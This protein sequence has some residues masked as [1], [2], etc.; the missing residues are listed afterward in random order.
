MSSTVPSKILVVDDI[1]ENLALIA[2]LLASADYDVRAVTSGAAALDAVAVDIPDL[3]LLDI[4]MPE[5]DGFEVCARLKADPRTVDVPVIF[6][7]ASGVLS[8]KLEAFRRGGADYVEKPFREEEML[9][10]VNVHVSLRKTR[11]ELM[12]VLASLENTVAERT[13]SLARREAQY[14]RLVEN[15]PDIIYSR[16]T[17]RGFLYA[18]NRLREILGYDIS[19]LNRN[20]DIWRNSVHPEDRE[21]YER[22]LAHPEHCEGAVLEY[23]IRDARDVWHWLEERITLVQPGDD[24]TLIDGLATEVTERVDHRQAM[25]TLAYSDLLT[26]LAN[27]KRLH[28]YINHLPGGKAAEYSLL[29][30]DLDRFKEINDA[31]G[32]QIGDRVLV[33][34]GERLRAAAGDGDILVARL[35]GEDFALVIACASQQDA[36]SCAQRILS[37]L[38][39]PFELDGMRLE[40]SGSIGIA[41][42]PRDGGSAS[43][44]L[45]CADVA[46]YIAKRTLAGYSSYSSKT[47]DNSPVHPAL[48]SEFSAAI[49]LGQL[50]LFYQP[51]MHLGSGAIAGFEALLRWH[52]PQHGLLLPGQF[53]PLVE[54]TDLIR[55]L[56][57]WVIDTALQQLKS[58]LSGGL[59]L[60]V[61][62]NLSA[63]NLLDETIPDR[64]AKCLTLHAI[65]P[66][67]LEVEITET[68]MLIDPDRS[69]GI[70]GRIAALGVGLAVDDFG[71][72]YSSF[73][74]VHRF[75]KPPGLKI[76]SSFVQRMAVN[77]TDA[78]IVASMIHLAHSIEARAIAEGVEDM[79]T[80]EVLRSLGCHQVQGY[81]LARPMPAAEVPD[82]LARHEESGGRRFVPQADQPP[83]PPAVESALP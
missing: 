58:W 15:A 26:G 83:P 56:T 4:R 7:S 46:M 12:S 3:V 61:A 39:H 10:R 73:S 23:R 28:E 14:K 22:I 66:A 37:A 36:E 49:D 65:D 25:E 79:Q 51:K 71:T 70:L 24:E 27:R 55:P 53:L 52:H 67:Q 77:P 81:L 42:A 31:L 44:M 43:E 16:S 54:V 45:R 75:P 38:D 17:R 1:A 29:L 11:R 40:V 41:C 13:D 5:M 32:H 80:L 48:L 82:W 63:R 19:D 33:M 74:R 30:I 34:L 47:N 64:I 50:A 21:A 8:D 18:N 68:S 59:Q 2:R 78:A 62:I 60:K 72:G 57:A 9:A 20:P 35:G 69:T 76:D 6:L